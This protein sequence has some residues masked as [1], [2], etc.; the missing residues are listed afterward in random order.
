LAQYLL[1]NDRND[2]TYQLLREGLGYSYRQISPA[3]LELIDMTR[4]L[5]LEMGNNELANQ[6]A[7]ARQDYARM[8]SRQGQHKLLTSY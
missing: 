7:Q 5:V 1:E 3:Y 4:V 2:E 6:L 8:L